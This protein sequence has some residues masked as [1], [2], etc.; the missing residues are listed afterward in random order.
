M[1]PSAGEQNQTSRHQTRHSGRADR[2]YNRRKS[3]IRCGWQDRG[4]SFRTRVEGRLVGCAR[5]CFARG[6]GRTSSAGV[7][8]EKLVFAARVRRWAENVNRQSPGGT[9]TSFW[10]NFT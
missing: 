2:K 9:W 6:N 1:R 4:V 8:A 10:T 3:R 5:K 7:V